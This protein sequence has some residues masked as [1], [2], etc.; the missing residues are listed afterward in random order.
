MMVVG[1]P[2]GLLRSSCTILVDPETKKAIVV[3]VGDGPTS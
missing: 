3:D 2:V 1:F